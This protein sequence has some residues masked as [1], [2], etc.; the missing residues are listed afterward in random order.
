VKQSLPLFF[1]LICKCEKQLQHVFVLK[2]TWSQDTMFDIRVCKCNLHIL[3][4]YLGILT[5]QIPNFLEL[6]HSWRQNNFL[7]YV[8][9]TKTILLRS[10]HFCL[11]KIPNFIA[12]FTN[13]INYNC[14][15]SCKEPGCS[16]WQFWQIDY[17]TLVKCKYLKG[18]CHEMDIFLKV[19]TF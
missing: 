14:L 16:F 18:Q 9:Y 2:G 15:F 7:A 17:V 10:L 12:S 8:L 5:F 19:W 4:D 3:M 13:I 6:K 11:F 1:L